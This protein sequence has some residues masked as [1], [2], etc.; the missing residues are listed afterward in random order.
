M[1][2]QTSHGRLEDYAAQRK[3]TYDP[4]SKSPEEMLDRFPRQHSCYHC[5]GEIINALR[6]ESNLPALLR[7]VDNAINATENGCMFY[8]WL[9][10]F[11]IKS[12]P[13]KL[14]GYEGLF[15]DVE[16]L[17]R[18]IA[19][20]HLVRFL[21]GWRSYSWPCATFDV[22]ADE[23][24]LPRNDAW[25]LSLLTR[26]G[27]ASASH[28]SSRTFN[29]HV[30]SSA[31]FQLANQWLDTCR[32]THDECNVFARRTVPTRLINLK[33][34]S[35]YGYVKIVTGR[36]IGLAGT[37]NYATLSYCWGGTQAIKT[38]K[39]TLAQHQVGIRISELGQSIQ[40]AI[41]VALTLGIGFLWIDSLCIVQDDPQ[42]IA[43]EISK[44]SEYYEN[45]L[46]CISAASATT[47]NDGFL[48][49]RS[50]N[51]YRRGPFKLPYRNSN[52]VMG[53]IK[54]VTYS[55]YSEALEPTSNRAWTMQESLLSPRLLSYSY[56]TLAWSCQRVNHTDGGPNREWHDFTQRRNWKNSRTLGQSRSSVIKYWKELVESYSKRSL[57]KPRDKLLAISGLAQKYAQILSSSH[58]PSHLE[59]GSTNTEVKYLAGVWHLGPNFHHYFPVIGLQLFWTTPLFEFRFTDNLS[60]LREEYLQHVG[61]SSVHRFR[62]YIAPS[63]SWAAIDGPIIY[64]DWTSDI[65]EASGFRILNAEVSVEAQ[66][67]LFGAVTSGSLTVE[68]RMREI[69]AIVNPEEPGVV[70]RPDTEEDNK[71]LYKII[72]GKLRGWLLEV[73]T[74]GGKQK[75]TDPHWGGP[76]PKGLILVAHGACYR[77]IGL[78]LV[79][80]VDKSRP[81]LDLESFFGAPQTIT[82]I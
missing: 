44:M 26:A 56:Q 35:N 34:R 63:W 20:I 21:I 1:N 78:F 49:P 48:Q 71:E 47:C 64:E 15:L 19:N 40:D 45:A 24:R 13:E 58:E 4:S 68:G 27:N 50:G 75:F 7:T 72:H 16:S 28:I 66:Q 61:K 80:N 79:E 38:T 36:L 30:G 69:G 6:P 81:I 73:A 67:S 29:R 60:H 14:A 32:M 46:V 55:D 12:R 10:D 42:D 2:M 74:S 11:V 17:P 76:G 25:D 39:S 57:T 53:S 43:A 33:S 62:E 70:Y 82:I 31:S 54:L 23:G 59:G 77:R 52:H 3:W 37:A 41:R 9:L 22:F 8:E 5:E 51:P 18:D 65:S